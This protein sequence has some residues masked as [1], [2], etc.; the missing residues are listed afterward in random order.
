M[1]KFTSSLLVSSLLLG[2]LVSAG[3]TVV[4]ASEIEEVPTVEVQ[5]EN[6]DE[7]KIENIAD[8]YI[9]LDKSTNKF[10]INS[11]I[12]NELSIV[13]VQNISQK[14]YQTNQKVDELLKNNDGSFTATLISPNGETILLTP[15]AMMARSAGKNDI[16]IHWNYARIYLSKNSVNNIIVG[17]TGGLG[18]L[19]G[20]IPGVGLGV[21]VACG[22]VLAVVGNQQVS[23]GIWFDYNYFTGLWTNNWGWQ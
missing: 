8:K 14:V 9:Y 3:A 5:K 23:N 20:F 22:I 15:S 7:K 1:K 19:V 16:Q 2:I 4:N 12:N 13:E 18:A 11:A 21:A 10:I 17:G 6:I